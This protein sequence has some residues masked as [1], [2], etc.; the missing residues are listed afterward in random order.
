MRF[1]FGLLLLLCYQDASAQNDT[2]RIDTIVVMGND[3]TS[4]RVVL[5]ELTLHQGDVIPINEFS[6]YLKL[7]RHFLMNTGLFAAV[8]IQFVEWESTTNKVQLM[9]KVIE[10]WYIYPLPYFDLADRS[11]NVWLKEHNASLQRVNFGIDFSHLNL[12]GH[13]DLLSLDLNYGY[14]RR[15][16]VVY[17][18]P[19][20]NKKET[21]GL[22][23]EISYS[24]NREF[25]FRTSDNKQLFFDNEDFFTLTR[26]LLVSR[27]SFRPGLRHNHSFEIGYNQNRIAE[28]VANELN[29]S[30]FLNGRS[31][32]RFFHLSYRFIFDDRDVRGYPLNGRL[33]VLELEKAGLGIF[34]NRDGLTI[35]SAL[36][37]YTPLSKR[38]FLNTGLQGKYSLIRQQQPYNDNRAVGFNGNDLRGYEYYIIDGADM[39]IAKAGLQFEC[40]SYEFNFGKLMPLEGYRK[41]PFKLYF[42]TDANVGY[43]NNPFSDFDNT[44]DNKWLFGYGPGIDMVLYYNM[45]VSF[46]YSI[47]QFGETGL[48]FEFNSN[49]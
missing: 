5:R 16:R 12:T 15:Y 10:A 47:N 22:R 43:V 13:R 25:N 49:L 36:F 42:T 27:L 1:F 41:M 2:V 11:F 33:F 46:Q 21:L 9:V 19:Y 35:H 29:P 45:A 4:T 8:D 32:Q 14:T 44:L 37:R 18:Y 31:F 28:E 34:N 40:F 17:R 39:L 7:S 6:V 3:H 38:L 48:F 24:R 23:S 26:F 30:Y 20:L